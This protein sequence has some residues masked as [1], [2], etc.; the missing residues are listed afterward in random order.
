M[1]GSRDEVA[2]VKNYIYQHYAEDLKPGDS[3]REGISVIR[4]PQLYFQ[5]RNWHEPE[6]FYTCGAHG[7]GEGAFVLIQYEGSAG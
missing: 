4:L 3:G 5:K 7:K 2:S 6:P 1:S